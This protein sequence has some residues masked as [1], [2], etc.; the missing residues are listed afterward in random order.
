MRPVQLPCSLGRFWDKAERVRHRGRGWILSLTPC[1]L[2]LPRPA[3]P[4]TAPLGPAR[5]NRGHWETPRITSPAPKR[6]N[7][8]RFAPHSGPYTHATA[9]PKPRVALGCSL[10]STFWCKTLF[11]GA[12]FTVPSR[13][14]YFGAFQHYHGL[15]PGSLA[16]RVGW[17]ARTAPGPPVLISAAVMGSNAIFP[18]GCHGSPREV[19]K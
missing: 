13:R 16:R 2:Q 12:P 11:F 18:G 1:L 8:R 15:N 9:P 14:S 17:G 3:A 7:T 10:C 5:G 19:T 6:H 4:P